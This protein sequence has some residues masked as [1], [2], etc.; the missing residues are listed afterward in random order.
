MA[1]SQE[2][3]WRGFEMVFSPWM[4]R[5]LAGVHVRH[6]EPAAWP[7]EVPIMLVANHVSWWDGFLL[8][9][10]Q[11]AR[12][13]RAPLH[14][15]MAAAEFRRQPVLRALG[16]LPLASSAMG[17][18]ALLREMRAKQQASPGVVFGYFPQGRIWPSSRR[19]LCFQPGAAWL[20]TH[21][22][23]IALVPVALHLEPLNRPSPTAFV[24]V[25]RPL[26]VTAPVETLA[27]E[28][29]V[30]GQLDLLLP[31][32]HRHGEDAPARWGTQ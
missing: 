21:L 22:A 8:R 20:A 32:L 5:R 19:P 24:G 30:R 16:A 9:E 4:S 29:M 13:P 6:E 28:E 23:P 27:L 18:R 3:R 26:T 10:V 31:F 1:L 17:P 7:A 14:V 12:R 11:R 2:T 25:G 15:V